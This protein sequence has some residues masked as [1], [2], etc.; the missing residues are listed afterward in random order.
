MQT[1]NKLKEDAIAFF[2]VAYRP[3]HESTLRKK[4][5]LML[6]SLLGI[7][8]WYANI[9]PTEIS[10]LGLK[11]SEIEP[12]KLL[13]I[14][15]VVQIYFYLAFTLSLISDLKRLSICFDASTIKASLEEAYEELDALADHNDESSSLLLDRWLDSYKKSN[16]TT[17]DSK[18]VGYLNVIMDGLFPF[19]L[20]IIGIWVYFSLVFSI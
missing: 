10:T 7:S 15:A 17:K 2:E 8:M 20:G 3:L 1:L 19:A 11:A 18:L 4:R 16:S 9:V 6:F 13:T 5:N 12:V 14:L